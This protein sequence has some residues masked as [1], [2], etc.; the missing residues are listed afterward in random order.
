[1][2]L[3][4]AALVGDAQRLGDAEAVTPAGPGEGAH[5]GP[6][7][8]ATQPD[9]VGEDDGGDVVHSAVRRADSN[10]SVVVRH[11]GDLGTDPHVAGSLV[12]RVAAD[13]PAGVRL[14]ILMGGAALVAAAVLATV[15]VRRRG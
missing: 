7:A 3:G 6:M 4:D 9:T 14:R 2:V 1:M 13:S 11:L 8:E 12:A 5:A 10:S 15:M